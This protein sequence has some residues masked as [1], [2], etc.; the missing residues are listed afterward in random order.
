MNEYYRLHIQTKIGKPERGYEQQ[1]K[2]TYVK[3]GLTYEDTRFVGKGL[4]EY[5]VR[6]DQSFVSRD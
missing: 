5:F 2:I 6:A 3:D 4:I 1:V